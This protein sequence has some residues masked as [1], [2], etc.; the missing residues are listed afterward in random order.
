VEPPIAQVEAWPGPASERH[1]PCMACPR[2]RS[3]SSLNTSS[4]RGAGGAWG[5][6]GL[7]IAT[8]RSCG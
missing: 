7:A 1:Q 3:S 8:A 6:T 2:R 5:A 4:S